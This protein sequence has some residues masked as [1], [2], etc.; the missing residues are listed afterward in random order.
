MAQVGALMEYFYGCAAAIPVY[1]AELVRSNSRFL[2]L[3]F[4]ATGSYIFL[5]SFVHIL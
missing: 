5:I 4:S 3:L 2:F 1:D